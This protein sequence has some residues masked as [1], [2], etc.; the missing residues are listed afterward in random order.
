MLHLV[1]LFVYSPFL[2]ILFLSFTTF[3]IT[4]PGGNYKAFIFLAFIKDLCVICITIIFNFYPQNM[5]SCPKA[6]LVHFKFWLFW[7]T[8][9]VFC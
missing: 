3:F 6:K 7:P 5:A 8:G 1:A 4:T 2:H 9:D